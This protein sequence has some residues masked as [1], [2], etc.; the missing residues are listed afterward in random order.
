VT[1]VL[2]QKYVK[3]KRKEKISKTKMIIILKRRITPINSKYKLNI[4]LSLKAVKL[5]SAGKFLILLVKVQGF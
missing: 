1:E 3:L 2:G 4:I 5:Y